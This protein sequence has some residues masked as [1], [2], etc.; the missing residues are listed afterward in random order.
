MLSF[1]IVGFSSVFLQSGQFR[2]ERTQTFAVGSRC[3][4]DGRILRLRPADAAA[5]HDGAFVA[6]DRAAAHGFR[7]ADFGHRSGRDFD[8]R[9]SGTF[10]IIVPAGRER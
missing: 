9:P 4:G 1:S 5:R 3:V 7:S 8:F 2:T 6:G 10:R